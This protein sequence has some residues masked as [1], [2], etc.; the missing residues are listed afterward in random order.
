MI[1]SN[2][3]TF[4]NPS[5]SLRNRLTRVLWQITWSCLFRPS[6]PPLHFWRFFLLR[7]FGAKIHHSCHVYN[8]VRIWAPWHLHMEANSCLGPNVICYSMAIVSLGKKAI[9]SQGTHLCTGSHDYES[10]DFQLFAKPIT[11]EA[12]VWICAE[13]FVGP[14]VTISCG[15]VIGARSV[16]I[17]DQPSWTVC[18]GNPCKSIKSR[19]KHH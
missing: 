10:V 14:G 9:V 4:E 3:N 16:V 19:K 11:I 17:K 15:A 12:D 6:P 5:F 2:V 18:G 1:L 13:S 8:S 7:L